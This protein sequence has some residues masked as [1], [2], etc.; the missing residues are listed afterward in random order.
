MIANHCCVQFVSDK[1]G[2]NKS[3]H[4]AMINFDSSHQ[5]RLARD[6]GKERSTGNH[7]LA[8]TRQRMMERG[9]RTAHSICRRKR[10]ANCERTK[11]RPNKAGTQQVH[12]EA[13]FIHTT[14]TCMKVLAQ[15]SPRNSDDD[16]NT[17]ITN[18]LPS[19]QRPPE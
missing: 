19:S 6:I 18:A 9:F 10:K 16:G 2:L 17:T 11:A 12:L 4:S 5:L 3:R 8:T 15:L 7:C 13:N 14:T 1:C